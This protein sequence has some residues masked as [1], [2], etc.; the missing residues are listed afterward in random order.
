M[1]LPPDQSAPSA[2]A[3]PKLTPKERR[4]RQAD[5]LTTIRLRMVIGRELDERG[6]TTP[7]EIG[8]ALGM[9]AAEATKLLRGHQWR[10][11]DVTLLEAAT[12]RLGVQ[13]PGP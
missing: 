4:A 9:P 13:V 7:T 3:K 2:P 8:D 12:A 1:N 10:E 11:G 5:R 6:I